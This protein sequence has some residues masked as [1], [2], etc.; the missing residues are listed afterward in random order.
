MA[1]GP[2]SG[3]RAPV[4]VLVDRGTASASEVFAAALQENG[5]ARVLGEQT[6]GKGLVQTIAKVSDGGAVVCTTARYVTPKGKDI[7]GVGVSAHVAAS[8][9]RS[10]V[11]R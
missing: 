11:P 7:N 2:Y 4:A 1:A 8:I 10:S 6:F 5:A 3:L 9:C